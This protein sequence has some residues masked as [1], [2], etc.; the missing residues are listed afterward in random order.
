[1]VFFDFSF[2]LDLFGLLSSPS[3]SQAQ[4]THALIRTH[5]HFGL[6]QAREE[7]KKR[8]ERKYRHIKH[9]GGEILG[10]LLPLLRAMAPLSHPHHSILDFHSRKWSPI[11]TSGPY[12]ETIFNQ[13]TQSQKTFVYCTP[14]P[15]RLVIRLALSLWIDPC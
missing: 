11:K 15:I 4:C 3:F 7:K 8:P 12:R 10:C 13:S 5:A 1:M 9:L 14:P 6:S 2:L